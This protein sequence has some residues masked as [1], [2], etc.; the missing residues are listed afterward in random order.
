MKRAPTRVLFYAMVSDTRSASGFAVGIG[1]FAIAMA[2][3]PF[4]QAISGPYTESAHGDSSVGVNRADIS[5]LGYSRAN[6]AHCHEQHAS[7]EGSEP[8]PV[9]GVPAAFCLFTDNFNT[10][11]TG[12]PYLESDNICFY[13]HN[14]FGSI[15]QVV[16]N[17]YAQTFGG[18]TATDGTIITS[19]LDAFTPYP[20]YDHTQHNLKDVYNYAKSQF[21]FFTDSSNPCNACHN[22][23]LAKRNNANPQ[24]PTYKAISR[25]TDHDTLWGDDAS[26]RMDSYTTYQPPFY[27]NST[28]TYEPDGSANHDGS[29]MPDYVT[30]CLDCHTNADVYSTKLARNLK[31]I[32]W[33]PAGDIHG[34]SPRYAQQYVSGATLKLP[35][36]TTL[37]GTT[38]NYILSCTDCHEP[39]G[40][41]LNH[42]ATYP[43]YLLRKM[44]NGERVDGTTS[45]PGHLK[46]KEWNWSA[47]NICQRCHA[48][49]QH[50]GGDLGC[51]VCHYHGS[52]QSAG[53]T[54][55]WGPHKAF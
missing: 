25:P 16:N 27:Y 36:D 44:L 24:D 45:G 34:G 38:P 7:I 13:C 35:Y 47:L 52:I 20:G 29:K 9:D 23:H 11:A 10:A 4:S 2:L 49:S 17:N 53:C 30:F 40:T 37:G 41:V 3:L 19:I 33:G 15:M 32:D 14:D 50:C 1:I 6:C 48:V 55:S 39:H 31:A 42:T 18:Y 22:P 46:I 21:V 5:A 54:A 51:T 43:S 12:P 26:E 8:A 28:T